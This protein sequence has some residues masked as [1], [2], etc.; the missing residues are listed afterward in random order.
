M[1]QQSVIRDAANF[2]TRSRIANFIGLTSFLGM[3]PTWNQLNREQLEAKLAEETFARKTLS[4]YRYVQID[5]P[6][7]MRD[8]LFAMWNDLGCLGRI[9]VAGEGINAQMNV[10]EPNWDTFVTELYALPEFTDVPFKIA[11]EESADSFLKLMIKVKDKIVADGIDDPSFDPSNTGAY[12][13]AAG[14]NQAIED[15][16]IVLDMRNHYESEVGRFDNAICPPADTFREEIIQVETLLKGRENEKVIMYCTG[17]IRCEKASAY[18]RHIGFSDV[19]H[20]EGGVIQYAHECQAQGLESRFRGKNFVFDERMGE[21]IT[22]DVIARC[23]QCGQASDQHVNCANDHCHLLFLQ[24]ADCHAKHQGN[25]CSH[26]CRDIDQLG[27]EEVSKRFADI[28]SLDY[29]IQLRLG[30]K[31]ANNDNSSVY[32]S[33]LRP[34]LSKIDE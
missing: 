17:G 23:H 31:N 18:L 14:F 2:W 20:L 29:Q 6:Q 4:F 3:K 7:G 15:G 33:R 1:I 27:A 24:C 9:Y 13:D 10:P 32:K 16:A 30:Y 26:L 34:K 28:E 12:L 25:Y 8:R 22:D 5:D 11:V 21:R 19:H